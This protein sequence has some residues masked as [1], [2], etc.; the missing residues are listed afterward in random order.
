MLDGEKD[1]HKIP[2]WQSLQ[3]SQRA[4]QLFSHLYDSKF[5]APAEAINRIKMA[6]MLRRRSLIDANEVHQLS[7]LFIRLL[8]RRTSASDYVMVRQVHPAQQAYSQTLVQ[9]HQFDPV[10]IAEMISSYEALKSYTAEHFAEVFGDSI[11]EPELREELINLVAQ[12]S[13]EGL[14]GGLLSGPWRSVAKQAL[15]EEYAE[16][17][18]EHSEAKEAS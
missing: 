12:T 18:K 2:R 5:A 13:L 6:T 4:W 16:F 14:R 7:Q 1:G 11:S 15:E 10:Q 9:L 3:F 8:P 17:F